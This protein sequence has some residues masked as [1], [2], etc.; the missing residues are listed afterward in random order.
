VGAPDTALR[1]SRGPFA[2]LQSTTVS[3]M[4]RRRTDFS[5]QEVAMSRAIRQTLTLRQQSHRGPIASSFYFW[6]DIE[7]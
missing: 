4:V 5:H 7:G 2:T 3:K 1:L 6:D